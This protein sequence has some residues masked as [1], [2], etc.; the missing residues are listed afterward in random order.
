MAF[1]EKTR[2]IREAFRTAIKDSGYAVSIIDE[3]E[4]NNQIVTEIFYEIE[5]SKFVVVDVQFQTMGLTM[6]PDMLR[7]WA[8]KLLCAAEKLSLIAIITD[9][10]LMWLK[11]Q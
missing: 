4:H 3:K 1:K 2:S 10:T 7:H 6:K 9:H 11:N 8:N 5:R